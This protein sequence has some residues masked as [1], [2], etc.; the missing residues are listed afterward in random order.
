M[1]TFAWIVAALGWI[2]AIALFVMFRIRTKDLKTDIGTLM[3]VNEKL[4][5][6]VGQKSGSIAQLFE[7]IESIS[8]ERTMYRS[9]A[10]QV[11]DSIEKGYGIAVRKEVTKIIVDFNKLELVVFLAG[12]HKLL[13]N[14]PTVDDSEFYVNLIKRLQSTVDKMPDEEKEQHGKI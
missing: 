8:N 11:E 4:N 12:I 9:R 1:I 13:K 2:I 7:M 10:I 6:D 14:A 3:D 5:E